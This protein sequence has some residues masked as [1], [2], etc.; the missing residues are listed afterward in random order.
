MSA[1]IC[2]EIG[3]LNSFEPLLAGT[4]LGLPVL[5]ADGMGRAFP[6]LQVHKISN[7][8]NSLVRYCY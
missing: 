1:L 4:R 6:E 3:G 8:T 2:A 7:M 5:D